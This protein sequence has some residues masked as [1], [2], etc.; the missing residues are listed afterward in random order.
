MRNFLLHWY[1][2]NDDVQSSGQFITKDEE[3]HRICY[4]NVVLISSSVRMKSEKLS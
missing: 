4:Q 3:V 2:Q 1:L